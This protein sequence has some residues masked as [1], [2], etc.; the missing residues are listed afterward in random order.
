MPFFMFWCDNHL[1]AINQLPKQLWLRI[2]KLEHNI[3]TISCVEDFN[4]VKDTLCEIIDDICHLKITSKTI[5]EFVGG[6]TMIEKN[7]EYCNGKA[8]YI[9]IDDENKIFPC[10]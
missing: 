5:L 9:D 7:M 6:L 4:E 8:L 10:K 2:E 3:N 1:N